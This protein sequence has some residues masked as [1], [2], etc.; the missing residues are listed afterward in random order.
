VQWCLQWLKTTEARLGVKP[1]IY[2]NQ[3]TVNGFDWS[4]VVANNNGL[5]LAK[6]DQ[7]QTV[8]AVKWWNGEAIKQYWDKGTVGGVAGQ[9]DVD[10]FFGDLA[11]L[12]R[13]GKQVPVAPVAPSPAPAPAAP[14]FDVRAWRASLGA[15][16]AVF[17]RLQD[18]A[19]RCFPAYAHIAPVSPAYGPQTAAFLAEFCRRQGVASDG[20]DIGPKTAQLLFD[21]GF[22]G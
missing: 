2:L 15:T 9:V 12:V 19:N 16:G 8:T 3:S 17:A 11:T 6:Y 18:W 7:L 1:L 22:R 4:P 21:A 5:W 13:Y 14:V 10:V 20:K